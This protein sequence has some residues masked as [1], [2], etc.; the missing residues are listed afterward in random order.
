MS[1]YLSI[2]LSYVYLSFFQRI[3]RS[4]YC[5]II[6]LAY[7]CLIWLYLTIYQSIHLIL[8]SGYSLKRRNFFKY[9]DL[10]SFFG[11]FG[12]IVNFVLI[13]FGAYI[14][15]RISYEFNNGFLHFNFSDTSDGVFMLTWYECLIFSAVLT[16]SDEVSARLFICRICCT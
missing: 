2:D 5:C 7:R 1:I 3:S 12:T 13:T 6:L 14:Y 8:Y 15:G 4:T 9:F 11:I 16:G 10:I